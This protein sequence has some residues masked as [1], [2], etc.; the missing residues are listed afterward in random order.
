MFLL[1]KTLVTLIM[2][3]VSLYTDLQVYTR[4]VSVN[5]PNYFLEKC[6]EVNEQRVRVEQKP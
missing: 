5:M 6:F 4:S 3:I 2:S 1:L